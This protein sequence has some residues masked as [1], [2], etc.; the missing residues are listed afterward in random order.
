MRQT[1]AKILLDIPV[2]AQPCRSF[3]LAT[4]GESVTSVGGRVGAA[5]TPGT[6]EMIEVATVRTRRVEIVGG[7]GREA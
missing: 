5:A 1:V 4:S 3:L 6:S 7:R 2:H